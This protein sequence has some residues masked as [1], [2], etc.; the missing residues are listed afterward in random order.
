MKNCPNCGE[1]VPSE[2]PRCPNCGHALV[3]KRPPSCGAIALVVLAIL[4]GL[5]GACLLG[6]A[7]IS[8]GSGALFRTPAKD[9]SQGVAELA[10]VY[11]LVF[12]VAAVTVA[13][14]ARIFWRRK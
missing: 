5:M 6:S 2:A 9:L 4:F 11:G 7:L 13:V 14:L 12:A 8:P 3:K 1:D 10:A